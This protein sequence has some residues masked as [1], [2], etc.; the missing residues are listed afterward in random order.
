M[1]ARLLCGATKV[2]VEKPSTQHTEAETRL[3]AIE[4]VLDAPRKGSI[5][6]AARVR[7]LCLTSLTM[8]RR[9]SKIGE[10]GA[11]DALLTELSS[12]GGWEPFRDER[13]VVVV[14]RGVFRVGSLSDEGQQKLTTLSRLMAKYTGFGIELVTHDAVPR[15]KGEASLDGSREVSL[16]GAFSAT[17]LPAWRIRVEHAGNRLPIVDGL[18]TKVRARNERVEVVFVA[19]R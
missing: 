3:Y 10:I 7:A 16:R 5:D 8:A 2:L 17:S 6:E 9:E 14:L 18:D 1:E 19:P 13:G 15:G 11:S 12:L 4:K